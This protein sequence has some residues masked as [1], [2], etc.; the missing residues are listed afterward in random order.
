MLT[1]QEVTVTRAQAEEAAAAAEA[2]PR[3]Q[4]TT[5][6]GVCPTVSITHRSLSLLAIAGLYDLVHQILSANYITL[7]ARMH[8][9]PTGSRPASEADGP[10]CRC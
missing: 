3:M 10:V 4:A 9:I 6:F 8:I 5:R 7:S 1:V 2:T